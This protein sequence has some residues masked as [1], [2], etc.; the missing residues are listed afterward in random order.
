MDILSPRTRRCG[1]GVS[2]GY[3]HCLTALSIMS[4]GHWDFLTQR[5]ASIPAQTTT[6]V[7]VLWAG[8]AAPLCVFC[9]RFLGSPG[10]QSP[11]PHLAA[12]QGQEDGHSPPAPLR[13]LQQERPLHRE[14]LGVHPTSTWQGWER[15][16]QAA[17]SPP[18]AVTPHLSWCGLSCAD[19]V[20]PEA[21]AYLNPLF[22]RLKKFLEI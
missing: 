2:L 19:K 4:A 14:C 12:P 6:L 10:G 21:C 18:P 13:L 15:L 5:N 7:W 3:F 22:C 1:H 20:M 9:R 11:V 8:E 16:R 17:L